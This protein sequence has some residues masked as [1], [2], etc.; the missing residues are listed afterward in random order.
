MGNWGIGDGDWDCLGHVIGDWLGT[1]CVGPC[2][3][4]YYVSLA[5]FVRGVRME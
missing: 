3:P 5:L 2:S 4:E 1:V